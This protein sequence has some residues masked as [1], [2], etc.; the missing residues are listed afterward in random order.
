M[1]LESALEFYLCFQYSSS[2]L[3]ASS[4]AKCNRSK[5][6]QYDKSELERVIYI[7]SNTLHRS[8]IIIRPS[9]LCRKRETE[10]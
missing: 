3:D 1:L 2:N 10:V 7:E 4:L 5:A 9:H 6:M 8:F